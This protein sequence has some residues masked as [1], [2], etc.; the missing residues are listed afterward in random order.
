MR[1]CRRILLSAILMVSASTTFAQLKLVPKE[2]L[3]EIV[4]PRH[5]P[6]SAAFMFV[7]KSIDAGTMN[8]ADSPMNFYYDF[9]NVGKDTIHLNQLRTTCSCV[10]VSIDKMVVA[11]GEKGRVTARYNPK[12]H[13]G[14]FERRI[15]IYT[16]DLSRPAAMLKLTAKVEAGTEYS[17]YPIQK[18]CLRLR[19]EEVSFSKGKKA[20]ET[21]RVVNGGDVPLSLGCEKIFLPPCIA[22][23]ANPRVLQQGQTGE[24][25]IYYDPDKGGEN[26]NLKLILKGLGVPP[27]QSVIK[28]RIE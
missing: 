19:R 10:A 9:T 3:A 8:E 23:D 4:S 27:S 20:I 28:I 26:V 11:P 13:P 2:K 7:T 5:S 1:L 21:I 15:F 6:D 14:I 18:G 25:K 17:E 22:F 16:V 24:L 12:G